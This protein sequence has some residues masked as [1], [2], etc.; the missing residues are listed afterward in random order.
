VV[1][2]FPAATTAQIL[3]LAIIDPSP[4]LSWIGP[5]RITD[6]GVCSHEFRG[7]LS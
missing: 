4:E 5:L 3:S 7:T 1:A 2:A 6:A